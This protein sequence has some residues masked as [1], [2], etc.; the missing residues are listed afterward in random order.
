[1]DEVALTFNPNSFVAGVN[2]MTKAMTT[3]ENNNSKVDNNFKK[4]TDSMSS[5]MV[6]KGMLLAQ[7]ITSGFKSMMNKIPEVGKSFEIAGDIISRNLLW[8]L[9][10]ELIPLLQGMLNWVRDHRAMFV[11]WGQVIANVFRG[12]VTIVKGAV[13]A[14]TR[15]FKRLGE[16]ISK[17]FGG[18]S[19]SVEKILNILVFKI[20]AVMLFMQAIME[21]VLNWVV[22]KLIMMLGW[23]KK[24]FDGFSRGVGN[25]SPALGDLMNQL[26]RL[27]NLF[28]IGEGEIGVIGKAFEIFGFILGSTVQPAILL[29]AEAI[30]SMITSV[31]LLADSF[32][33]LGN[34]LTGDFAAAGQNLKSMKSEFKGFSG[35]TIDRGKEFIDKQKATYTGVYD[36]A[37]SGTKVKA[38]SGSI[39][40]N[41]GNTT[42]NNVINA[43]ITIPEGMNPLD[44]QNMVKD[45]MTKAIKETQK[46]RGQ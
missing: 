16:G 23:V 8:P 46:T 20:V 13:E 5:F 22:D 17:V 14:W 33:F 39:M 1:M 9:R 36:I 6:A 44:A 41:S 19:L 11:R 25:I 40:T 29:I 26:S 15:I 4:K 43:P 30:D 28:S 32:K 18:A 3:F 7:V 42:N 10:K 31:K 21:P 2:Q 38:S 27:W 37:T 24:F 12:I 34:V 35:R 45:A